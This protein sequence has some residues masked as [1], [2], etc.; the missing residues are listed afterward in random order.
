VA[1]RRLLRRAGLDLS[2]RKFGTFGDIG[3]L[4]FYPAHHITMG[5]GG[6]VFTNNP[7][8]N[9]ILESFRDWGRDCYC[10][11]GKRQHLRQAL[12]L[13]ARRPAQ[14]LRPQVHL[15][16]PRL[17]PEDHR[18]AGGLRR[19]ATR[20]AAR[21]HRRAAAQLRRLRSGWRPAEFLILPEATPGSDPSWFG[22]P[23]TLR[24]KPP[25]TASTCSI[26]GPTSASAPACCLPAT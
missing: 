8:L 22:F 6:A 19:G 4:S 3:T 10:A 24:R 7:Q 9:K 21:L 15:L 18:H 16:A 26:P 11:P 17:Q 23:I 25:A 12:Q 14:G 20:P 2:G 1:D 5:E 13:A